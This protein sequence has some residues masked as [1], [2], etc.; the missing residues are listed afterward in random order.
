MDRFFL[1]TYAYQID[2]RGLPEARCAGELPCHGGLV[3]DLTI[4]LD[5]RPLTGSTRANAAIA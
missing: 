4:V 3:P 1:S 5:S 2:G